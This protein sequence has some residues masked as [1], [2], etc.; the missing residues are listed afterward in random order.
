[1]R[2]GRVV[3]DGHPREVLIGTNAELLASTGLRPPPAARIS[4]RLGL[5]Q[6]VLDVRSLLAAVAEARARA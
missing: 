1:M 6:P 4:A 2:H 3:A 5:A